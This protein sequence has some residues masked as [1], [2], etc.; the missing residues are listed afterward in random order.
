M[1]RVTT[2]LVL[3]CLLAACASPAPE[4]GASDSSVPAETTLGPAT[5]AGTTTVATTV[6]SETAPTV[7]PEGYREITIDLGRGIERQGRIYGTGDVG[8][9]LAHMGRPGDSQRDWAEFARELAERGYRVLTFDHDNQFVWRV[10]LAGADLLRAEGVENVIAAGAS[11]GAMGAL[12]AAEE[13][14]NGLIGVVWLAEVKAGSGYAF[15]EADVG[16]VACPVFFASGTGDEYGAAED[17]EDLAAIAPNAELL[18]VESDLHGTDILAEG[19][20]VADELREAMFGFIDRV[21]A[22]PGEPC[23]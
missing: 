23:G 6:P 15:M 14:G 5:T 10:V 9:V 18:L 11:I 1:G 8:V 7:G 21:A 16:A 3:V 12:R 20:P 17:A 13:P 2:L 19:G 22:E 4:P